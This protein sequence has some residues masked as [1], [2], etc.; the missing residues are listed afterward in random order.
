MDKQLQYKQIKMNKLGIS[1]VVATVLLILL[2][3]VSA[4]VIAEIVVPFTKK[5]LARSSECL[6]Y[7]EH[8]VFDDR[9]KF[10]CYKMSSGSQESIFL[11]LRAQ[12]DDALPENIAGFDLIFSG[13]SGTQVVPVR[14]SGSVGI[15]LYNGTATAIP[16]NGDTLTY[17]Y[18]TPTQYEK[19]EVYSALTSGR[20][21]EKPSSTTKLRVCGA[22]S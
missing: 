20:V 16:D 14:K 3:I 5:S 10:N 22:I 13:S 21:C 11:S 18:I 1:S 2:T 15:T 12:Q 4:A 9:L 19:V 7:Q 17:K 8:F 6:N